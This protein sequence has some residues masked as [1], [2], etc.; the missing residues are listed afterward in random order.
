MSRIGLVSLVVREYD[1]ALNFYCEKLGFE[2]AEDTPMN[3]GRRW[4]V[5]RPRHSQGVNLL[6]A[7]AKNESERSA[8]GNQTGGR[9]FLFL[10]SDNFYQDY[11]AMIQK[12]VIFVEEPREE[13]YG[14]VAVFQDLYGT[15]WDLIQHKDPAK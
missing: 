2:I 14:T 4:V 12:G 9:V 15:K 8:V 13:E 6:L 3:E 1:E 11:E 5:V 7:K 10:Y